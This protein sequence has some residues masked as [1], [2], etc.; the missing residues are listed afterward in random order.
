MI[1]TWCV[2]RTG[3]LLLSGLVQARSGAPFTLTVSS[4][5]LNRNGRFEDEYLPAGS[6]SGEG[7]N[8]TTVENDGGRRGVRWKT[9]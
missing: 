4:F 8:A 2:P 3:G 9:G 7:E 5:D 6:Y 1:G